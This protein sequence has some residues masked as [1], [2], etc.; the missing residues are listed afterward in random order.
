[1]ADST[2][3]ELSALAD[4]INCQCG[5]YK[6]CTVCNFLPYITISYVIADSTDSIYSTYGSGVNR[7]K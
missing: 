4:S 1:M 3:I 2:V 5:Q 6:F 7:G